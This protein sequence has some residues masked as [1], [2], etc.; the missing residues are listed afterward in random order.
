MDGTAGRVDVQIQY[1]QDGSTELATTIIRSYDDE[2]LGT[3]W[4]DLIPFTN[5]F[6]GSVYRYVKVTLQASAGDT[7]YAFGAYVVP[8]H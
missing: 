8:M 2:G 5:Q 7:E 3:S 1:S 6:Q 4:R